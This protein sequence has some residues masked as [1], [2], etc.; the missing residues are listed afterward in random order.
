MAKE[1]CNLLDRAEG[2][3]AKKCDSGCKHYRFDHLDTP[4]GL[5]EVFS[6]K[7]NELCYIYEPNK[8]KG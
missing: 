8:I 7:K 5:S 4:C 2:K 3:Q 1:I 6:V